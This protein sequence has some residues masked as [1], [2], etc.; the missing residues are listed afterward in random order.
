VVLLLCGIDKGNQR[1][2]I[3]QA[4]GY[5]KAGGTASS[6]PCAHLALAGVAPR[7]PGCPCI[8]RYIGRQKDKGVSSS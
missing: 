7:V 2:A 6:V 1:R 4:I 8:R 5:L 3:R